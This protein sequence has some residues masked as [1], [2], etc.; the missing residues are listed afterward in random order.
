[1]PPEPS[2]DTRQT[3]N[4]I[5]NLLRADHFGTG[6]RAALRRMGPKQLAEPALQRIL[7]DH[8]PDDWLGERGMADW[9]LIIHTLALGSPDNL[10]GAKSFG[11]ALAQA[12]YSESRLARLLQASRTQLN[13]VLPRACR[14][15][16]AKGEALNPAGIASFVLAVSNGA[17]ADAARTQIA[18]D[19]Y[20]ASRQTAATQ[21]QD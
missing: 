15:L 14:F 11:A 21:N 8:I 4:K 7:A 13:D 5:A 3:A 1:M 16:V 2:T 18:R 20:R 6:P 9:G 10:L 12:Q 17:R 19:F